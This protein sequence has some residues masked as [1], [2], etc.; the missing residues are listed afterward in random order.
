M[1]ASAAA[2][3]HPQPLETSG[4]QP[5]GAVLELTER[6][7]ENAHELW[8]RERLAQ[9]WTYGPK[10]DDET[11]THPC[12]IPYKDLPEEEKRFDREAAIGTLKAMLALGYVVDRPSAVTSGLKFEGTVGAEVTEWMTGLDAEFA[13]AIMDD[14]TRGWTFDMDDE[15][16]M[17]A[18]PETGC[19]VA[20]AALTHL[21]STVYPAWKEA[22]AKA[23]KQQLWHRRV[24]S[25][26]IGAGVVAILCAVLQLVTVELSE[27]T[28]KMLGHVELL[29]IL[30]AATAVIVGFWRH[31]HHGWLSSRQLAE[32]LR[33][34]KFEA[35]SWPELWCD[36]AQWKERVETAMK[37]L[38]SLKTKAAHHWAMEGDAV[39]WQMPRHAE[40]VISASDLAVV[41]ALYQSKRLRFQQH[42]F[43]Y[44]SRKAN[45][46]SRIV[47]WKIGL[48][49]FA[50]TV[51]VVL[52]HALHVR[53]LGMGE[54]ESDLC[55]IG[56]AAL[57]P[58][59]GFGLRAWLA[60]FETPRS[61]N[62]YRAKAH[63]LESYLKTSRESEQKPE[64]AL[65]AMA[66][67]EQ[68]FT[69]EHREWCRLQMEAEWFV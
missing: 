43:D 50:A 7:A 28:K 54:K 8:A 18:L 34:L 31:L 65:M 44:Q 60:A 25:V 23:M 64:M 38:L 69:N 3:Y 63:A 30:L 29:S 20:R 12:L 13:K 67:A 24:A 27:G 49:L 11:K 62:L 46:T 37:E 9:G 41:S 16:E 15:P 48:Y 47:D 51:G 40:C 4:V 59:V 14:A 57:I 6:L 19:P 26:A 36:L 2:S 42:Y 17:Q 33:I 61:R 5:S 68:F 35:L 55:L 56:L 45:S 10:R 39:T 66:Q 52:M 53:L 1:S 21:Q 22:D 32:R 58:V